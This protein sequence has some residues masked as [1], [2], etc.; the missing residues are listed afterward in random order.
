VKVI[1][2]SK[3]L[4]YGVGGAERSILEELKKI[5][6]KKHVTLAS[7]SGVK[8][9]NA[10]NLK[11]DLPRSFNIAM[12]KPRI[13]TNR[14]FFNEYL[15]NRQVIKDF[16]EHDCADYDELWAQ[17][18]WAPIAINSFGKK[19]VYFAR[20][21]SF[22]N[23]RPNYHH[24]FKR[25]AKKFYDLIDSP[26]FSSYCRDNRKA[27]ENADEVIANSTFMAGKI[28]ERFG[29]DSKVIYPFIDKSTIK[30]NYEN[31]KVDVPEYEKGIVLLGDSKIKGIDTVLRLA[32]DFPLEIFYI[33]SRTTTQPLKRNNIIYMPWV[34]SC[35]D[36]YKFAKIVIAPSICQE[37]YGRVAA[38][39]LALDIP[40]LVN[41]IGGLPEAVKYN[42]SL[43]AMNY[44]DFKIKLTQLLKN[45]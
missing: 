42:Q 9:F 45:Q 12:F 22:L 14:F 38:E 15:L 20:D 17:N 6:V 19:T 1:A 4:V 28:K 27:I 39:S 34:R 26:G 7:I 25:Y 43:I 32:D 24:G 44:Q 13:L 37:A 18:I 5:D 41:D 2:F 21:E 16:I 10:S 33:F 30:Q 11:L 23:I 29:R 35:E 3:N 36:A 31:I 40:C 8:S